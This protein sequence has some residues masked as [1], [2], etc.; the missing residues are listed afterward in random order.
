MNNRQSSGQDAS[1]PQALTDTPIWQFPTFPNAP[2]YWRATPTDICPN[3]GNPVSSITHASAA[4][5]RLIRRAN[6][7]R[8]AT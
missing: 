3:F 7:R 8:T 1:S 4:S 6:P 5:S 2:E